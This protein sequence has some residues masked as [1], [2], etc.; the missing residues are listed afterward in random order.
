MPADGSDARK[1]IFPDFRTTMQANAPHF[2]LFSESTTAPASQE[3][4]GAA[5]PTSAATSY[6][7]FVLRT[8]EGSIALDV[9]DAESD[10]SGE[11]LALWAV[12]RGLEAIPEPARVTLVTT[13]GWIRRGLRFGLDNWREQHWQWECFG[14]MTPIK[15]A[16]LWQRV[17]RALRFHEVECQTIRID[18][19]H[20]DLNHPVPA[21]VLHRRPFPVAAPEPAEP[22]AAGRRVGLGRVVRQAAHQLFLWCRLCRTNPAPMMAAH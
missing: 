20:D 18:R 5:E 14:R 17:D 21:T 13:S 16:D 3:P 6:W 7:H 22:A 8:Q 10:A 1:P 11:R 12:V 4:G 2:V 9:Q 15:N 19:P